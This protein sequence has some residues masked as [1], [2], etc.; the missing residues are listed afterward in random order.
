MYTEVRG[1]RLFPCPVLPCPV[2]LMLIIRAMER[3][4]FSLVRDFSP[5]SFCMKPAASDVP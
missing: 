3:F 4:F 2:R 1:G 5:Y